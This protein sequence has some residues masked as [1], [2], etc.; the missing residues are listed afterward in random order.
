MRS[1][2]PVLSFS[3]RPY[4]FSNVVVEDEMRRVLVDDHLR[5]AGAQHDQDE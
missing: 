1:P 3:P 5:P 2:T 4:Y